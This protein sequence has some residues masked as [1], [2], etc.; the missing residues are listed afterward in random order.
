MKKV[1]FVSESVN[2]SEIDKSIELEKLYKSLEE[3]L[4][5]TQDKTVKMVTINSLVKHY[6]PYAYWVGFYLL[7][8]DRL[9]IGPYQGTL[10]CLS[11]D[12]GK[13]VCGRV[14]KTKQTIIVDDISNL[15]EGID[16]ITCDNN[17]KS[18]IAL[19][20][21]DKNKKLIAVLDID[22]SIKSSFTVLDRFW[23]EKILNRHFSL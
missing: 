7:K 10:G 18:E 4:L 15:L 21:F 9:I 20:V 13:G 17:A 16:H 11:I 3:V 6:L 5:F 19:P 8:K 23:L 14:A 12:I 2:L 22:S 1:N